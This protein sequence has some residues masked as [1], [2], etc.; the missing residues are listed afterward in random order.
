[1]AVSGGFAAHVIWS[2]VHRRPAA[3]ET[4]LC[5]DRDGWF[6]A[7]ASFR[8]AV[9]ELPTLLLT[10]LSMSRRVGSIGLSTFHGSGRVGRVS[11]SVSF[12]RIGWGRVSVA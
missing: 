5:W 6:R 9:K 10:G 2:G 11:R 8:I 1:M 4:V 7:S 3:E 12:S